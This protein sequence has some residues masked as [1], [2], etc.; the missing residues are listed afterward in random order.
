M[1]PESLFSR[2]CFSLK[3]LDRQLRIFFMMIESC[4][5]GS[6]HQWLWVVLIEMKNASFNRNFVT[7][8]Y[9]INTLRLGATTFSLSS[10]S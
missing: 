8:I 4:A 7:S 5:C 3:A 1:S 10:I 9:W 6:T 2:S